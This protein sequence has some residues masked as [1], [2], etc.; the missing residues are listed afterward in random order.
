MVVQAFN[1]NTLDKETGRSLSVRPAWSARQIPGQPGLYKTLSQKINNNDNNNISNIK[2]RNNG[3]KDGSA[4][5][6]AY[7]QGWQPELRLLGP[8]RQKQRI[9]LLKLYMYK[10]TLWIN[11][12]KKKK[13][14]T[15]LSWKKLLIIYLKIF[16]TCTKLQ[17]VIF[18]LG[19]QCNLLL[20]YYLLKSF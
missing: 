14:Y 12:I 18:S 9:N 11:A 13:I 19:L 5:K 6:G 17:Q 15:F 2:I 10:H 16:S 3:W 8:S 4:G 7:C 1:L 20:T